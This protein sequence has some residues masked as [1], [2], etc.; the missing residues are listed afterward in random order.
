MSS[1]RSS[2]DSQ[3]PLP[4]EPEADAVASK[5][6]T[7]G[8]LMAIISVLGFSIQPRAKF[9]QMMVLDVLA[10]CV[11]SAVTL[12]MMYSCIKARQHTEVV[13]SVGTSI[14]NT[15]Y[16]PSASAVSGVWLFFQIYVVHSF[17]AKFQQF[18]FPVIIYS[19]VANVTFSYAPRMT[20]MAAAISMVT[21]LLEACLVGLALA[22]GVCLFIYPV[23]SRTVVFKQM[24]GYVGCLRGALQAHTVYFES[25]EESDMFG[26]A[27]TYDSK[28]EK[29]TK[30]G[31]VYSPEAQA[32]RTAVQKITE[33]H[34]KLHGD[35]TFAKREVA[36]GNLGPDDLQAIF[37]NLRQVM[38]PVVGL[39]FTVDLFQR[40]S[41]YNK[42]NTPIDPTATDIPDLVR[43]RVVQEWNDIMRAVHDPFKS[44]IQ[45]IDEGLQHI[46]FVLKLAKPP[47]KTATAANGE[48]SSSG[49]EDVE[50]SA[51]PS[52]GD[53]NFAAHLEQR[54]RDFKVA[55]RIALRTWSE[56]KGIKLPK[57][58]F[59]RPTDD[60]E[61]ISYG[62]PFI[63]RER[64][65]RQLS[66]GQMVLE[67][68]KFADDKRESGKLS[69]R[70]IIIPGWKRL[71]KWA[72]SLLKAEDTHEDDNI[73]D[74]NA[75]NN[76]LQLGE[77]YK[78]RKD[79]EHLRPE[80]T[81]QK[82]GDKVRLI[83]AM[84]R[85][86]ESAYGFRVACATMTIAIVGLL[87]DTQSFFIKQRF[88]WAMIMVNLSMT[89]TSGQSIF[90]FVLRILGTVLA[91][92]L[93][94]LS[95][96]IPGK[97][98]PGI[99][100][101][102]FIFLTCVFYVPIKLFRFRAIGIITI[103]TTS[104]IIGYE[105]QVR[106]V[107]EQV[108]TSNGQSYY[109]I[110]LLAPYRLATVTGGI[111]V[112]FFWTFFPYPISE[113]SVLRQSL[114]ASLYL[115][116][117]YYSLI[118]ET[119][120]ARV[121]GEAGDMAL[122][123]SAGRRLLKSRNQVFSKQMLM[124]NNLRTYSEFLKWE[125]PIGGRFPKK[126]Y[127]SII[128]CIENYL[129]LLGYASD[130]LLQI[131]DDEES[132]SAWLHDFKRLV[133]SAG[134]TTHEITSVLCLLSASI[135]DRRPLPPYL[136]TPRPYSFTK[137]LEAMDKDILSLKHIAEPGFATFAVL[138]IST[139]CIGG[140]V[141]RLMK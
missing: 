120:S 100:V 136:K 130:T 73:G 110:Y 124:L 127:D 25:L 6:T 31:K 67:F 140:D 121:R 131:G 53:K 79:P 128:A 76:I 36:F 111:A 91:M 46:S 12:L 60:M 82:I 81:F 139:R 87:H 9:I 2:E 40:L 137:R 1:H 75:Q 119:V 64:S 34:G 61:D 71:R 122:K 125:V 112:A 24:A 54:L 88:I 21:K 45:A 92:V 15:P 132:N 69:R 37:R 65:Q 99:I 89:P 50:A 56:E 52:P 57:D 27:E 135:T 19:I 94:F 133:A 103:I 48:T 78:H 47:K 43:H 105:L 84:F 26:R 17:R 44:M 30:D 38:I 141:E 51:V 3:W 32:I 77:A 58:F 35:L 72:T 14:V 4:D 95:W 86:Q 62:D 7:V 83:P 118:H 117:N 113:H 66:T 42:W 55:K 93:S 108:A 97:Q 33:I 11:A 96:Y 39:S 70:H 138:Q 114:G 106:K 13:S 16:N 126:Q 29:I 134:V 49:V 116:A 8:Y 18:Q 5:F 10:V 107:G 22:T 20:T 85:T 98:T 23:T 80:T 109:P 123:T 129:S 41:E 28:V 115:L 59:D 102:F 68:V 104:M 90:G 101:F 63:G 74:I